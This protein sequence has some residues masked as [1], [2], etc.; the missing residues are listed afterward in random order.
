MFSY[1]YIAGYLTK[2]ISGN[3][4][5]PNEEIRSYFRGKMVIYWK[6]KLQLLGVDMKLLQGCSDILDSVL[7][8]S[9]C[10]EMKKILE[11]QFFPKFS[12]LL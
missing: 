7:V 10:S 12:E 11:D 1:L 9:D 4:K 8:N 5:I 3:Y 2:D 6:N